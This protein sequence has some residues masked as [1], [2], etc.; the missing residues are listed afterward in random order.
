MSESSKFQFQGFII[1]R[2]LIER[3]DNEPTRKLSIGFKPQGVINK[4][5]GVFQLHLGVKIDDE[6][7]SL[8]IEIDATANFKFDTKLDKDSLSQFFY[9]NAPALLFPYIR[10]YIGT[11]TNLSGFEPINLPTL[12]ISSLAEELKRNTTEAS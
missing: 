9:L 11:L 2:S 3:N 7:K 12:N 10:A 8:N 4:E 1:S 6:K 5:D